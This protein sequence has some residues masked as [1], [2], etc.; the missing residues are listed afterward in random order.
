MSR[1]GQL[2]RVISVVTLAAQ[3][4][5]LGHLV[6]DAHTL[7]A[8][9]V[10]VDAASVLGDE[11]DETRAHLCETAA[12]ELRAGDETCAVAASWTQASV[13]PQRA[14]SARQAI[15]QDAVQRPGARMVASEDILGRAPKGSP[16]AA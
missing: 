11:H 2:R 1:Q 16:P 5:G 4:L 9:G 6:F 12:A 3:L 13:L 10:V 14:A 8:S 15:R 7:T